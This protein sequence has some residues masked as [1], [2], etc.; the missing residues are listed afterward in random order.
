MNVPACL[1]LAREL[2]V[3]VADPVLERRDVERMLELLR[4]RLDAAKEEGRSPAL[5][6]ALEEAIHDLEKG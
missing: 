1:D 2:R 4:V 5:I 3:D 6:R